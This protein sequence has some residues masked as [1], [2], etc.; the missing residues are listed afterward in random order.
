VSR[1]AVS[2]VYFV[3]TGDFVKI[4]VSTD[5]VKRMGAFITASPLPL[6]L[7]GVIPGATQSDERQLHQRFLGL[8]VNGEWF[9]A[10]AE[11]LEEAARWVENVPAIRAAVVAEGV[12]KVRQKRAP[13]GGR[14]KRVAGESTRIVAVRFASSERARLEALAARW[15]V[16]P[17]EA[18]R[19][20]V[21]E[22]ADR[23]GVPAAPP[24]PD[25]GKE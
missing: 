8:H 13:G 23:E 10:A 1:K 22:A 11:I 25:P 9:H 17:S 18:V 19:R 2:G 12:A 14:K 21:G 24:D 20:S 15:G 7:L 5:V 4:G 16:E 6:H 3:R